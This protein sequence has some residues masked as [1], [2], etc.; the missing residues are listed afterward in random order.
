MNQMIIQ[1]RFKIYDYVVCGENK[2]LYQLSHFKNKRTFPFKELTYNSKRKAYR[3][4]GQWV[5]K[6]RLYMLIVLKEEILDLEG[7]KSFYY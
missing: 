1:A 6:N 3:V 4:Y 2:K 5:S 7:N